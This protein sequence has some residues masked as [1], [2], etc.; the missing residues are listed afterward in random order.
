MFTGLLCPA[1]TILFVFK[2]ENLKLED[3]FVCV[4][5]L[6]FI[7]LIFMFLLIWVWAFALHPGPT[8][9]VFIVGWNNFK[10]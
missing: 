7:L 3:A 6:C 8:C 10:H 2:G 4:S 9:F 1:K 5:M